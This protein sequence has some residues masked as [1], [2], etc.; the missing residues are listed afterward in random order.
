MARL[1]D[2]RIS[3][4]NNNNKTIYPL[5]R[6]KLF[7]V[8]HLVF[9]PGHQDISPSRHVD[10]LDRLE[11][12]FST[13]NG[14]CNALFPAGIVTTKL[15]IFSK[16]INLLLKTTWERADNTPAILENVWHGKLVLQLEK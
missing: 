15:T 2:I 1:R 6:T 10:D 3:F 11:R 9:G 14:Y 12:R 16:T 13:G 7:I 8:P 4:S 5:L